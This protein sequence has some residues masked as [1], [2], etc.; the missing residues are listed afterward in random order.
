MRSPH[1]YFLEQVMAMTLFL[2]LPFNLLCLPLVTI[3]PPLEK[4]R[5]IF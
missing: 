3:Y 4:V 1:V 5:Q 2:F